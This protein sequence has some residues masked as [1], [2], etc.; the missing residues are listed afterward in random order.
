MM[1][2]RRS[3]PWKGAGYALLGVFSLVVAIPLLWTVS[4]ALKT[5]PEVGRD[6]VTWYP[7]QPTL[8]NFV[9]AWRILHLGRVLLNT[10]FVCV[11]VTV[12]IV[13]IS[14]LAGYAF[15]KRRFAGRGV[16]FALIIG[17]MTL[18]S[19]VLLL[20]TYLMIQRVGLVNNLWGLILPFAVTPLGIFLMRQFISQVPDELL[21]A[22][23]IDGLGEFGLFRQVVLPLVRPGLA[24]LAIL[25][26]VN[27]WNSFAIPLVVINDPNRFTINLALGLLLQ[28]FAIPWNQVMAVTAISIVPIAIVY[29]VLQRYFVSGALSGAVKG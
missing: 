3:S 29:L 22:G 27:N 20:P 19:G 24:A 15:A 14:A 17:L 26:F 23:R 2:V 6:P 10:L 18:P 5:L 7:H 8:E 12:L 4:T 9:E 11:T 25:E 13:F 1:A 21:E 28:G 16:L